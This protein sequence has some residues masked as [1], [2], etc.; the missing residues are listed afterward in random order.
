M[1]KHFL[2]FTTLLCSSLWL[3]TACKKDEQPTKFE[4]VVEGAIISENS[5]VRV[6]KVRYTDTSF[7]YLGALPTEVTISYGYNQSGLLTAVFVDGSKYIEVGHSSGVVRF[8]I[9]EEN[10]SWRASQL[11]HN[12]NAITQV[13]VKTVNP[14]NPVIRFPVDGT[15]LF[16]RIDNMKLETIEPR[17]TAGVPGAETF[18]TSSVRI[19]EYNSDGTPSILAATGVGNSFYLQEIT[20]QQAPG[21]PNKLKRML[22]E[23]ILRIN[24]M[25]G[26]RV[27]NHIESTNAFA[28]S[29]TGNWL[30]TLGLH[31]LHVL[32]ETNPNLVASIK[33][34]RIETT[35]GVQ[36]VVE[37]NT[38]NFLYLHDVDNRNIT[39]NG[40]KVFYDVVKQR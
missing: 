8:S 15:I 26:M 28:T 12:G 14:S 18:V 6:N 4:D 39:I 24:K 36:A 34:S 7:Q 20:Y 21:V 13:N 27:D 40:L 31:R 17:T 2:I 32:S 16:K 5:D 3:I 30:I 38:K 9:P 29:V 11:L 22:N 37:S 33:T 35:G 19:L 1:K 25:G 23:D 10:N